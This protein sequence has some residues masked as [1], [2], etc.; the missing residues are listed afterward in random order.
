MI[1][2]GRSEFMRDAEERR[3]RR[4]KNLK[5]T[6]ACRFARDD[7]AGVG[8]EF[9]AEGGEFIFGKLVENE[10]ADDDGV[11]GVMRKGGEVG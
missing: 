9:G 10:I 2:M 4:E 11:V 3:E 5:D 6:A 7:E 1:S 8:A